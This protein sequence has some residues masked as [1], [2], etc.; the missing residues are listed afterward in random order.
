MRLVI[1]VVVVVPSEVKVCS[2]HVESL[3]FRYSTLKPVM[4]EPLSAPAVH[5]T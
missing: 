3:K 5:E 1:V 2:V 4:E